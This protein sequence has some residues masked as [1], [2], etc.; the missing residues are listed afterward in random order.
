[1]ASHLPNNHLLLISKGDAKTIGHLGFGMH[2]LT[3][4]GLGIDQLV[5][6]ATKDRVKL[7]QENLRYSRRAMNLPQ[8]MYRVALARAY[9]AMYHAA[10]TVVFFIE[11]GDDYEAHLKLP[12][13]I[14]KDFPNRNQWEN[15][16]KTARLERNRADYDPY[17]KSDRAFGPVASSTLLTAESFLPIARGYL[18]RKGCRI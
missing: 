16:L 9:Y 8:P 11:R 1:M 7:A 10:R 15:D 3:V 12:K 14:P 4:S 2:V 17:P 6:N 18:V 5:E 13:H